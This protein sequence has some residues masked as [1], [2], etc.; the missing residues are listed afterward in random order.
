MPY[1]LSTLVQLGPANA[2]KNL[3]ATLVDT[4]GSIVGAPIVAGFVEFEDG[5]YL[6][7]HTY[8]DQFRGAV[9]FYDDMAVYLAAMAINPQEFENAD[10][11][12]S[13]IL[14]KVSVSEINV[15]S[16]VLEAGR[17]DIVRGDDYLVTNNRALILTPKTP[18]T[19]PALALGA[20]IVLGVGNGNGEL[21]SGEGMVIDPEVVRIEVLGETTRDIGKG[22]YRFTLRTN[23][24]TTETLAE[25]VLNL[26]DAWGGYGV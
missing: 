8:P 25:G 12:S 24:V 14:D 5:D 2:G 1:I 20:P 6:F 7:T 22:H 26:K 17:I 23:G 4:A 11:P 9:T 15:V 18:G 13:D 16:P 3:Q 21:F 10:T 19:W